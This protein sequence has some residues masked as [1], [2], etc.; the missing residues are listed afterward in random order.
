MVAVRP[1]DDQGAEVALRQHCWEPF[2]ALASN[3]TRSFL[4]F[5]GCHLEGANDSTGVQ[6][7]TDTVVPGAHG[8]V[9]DTIPVEIS[10]RQG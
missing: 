7:T 9:A 6:D 3:A 4:R 10:H 2:A 5:L 1:D 8:Q